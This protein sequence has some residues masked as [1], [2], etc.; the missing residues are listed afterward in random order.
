MAVAILALFYYFDILLIWHLF[1]FVTINSLFESF[2]NPARGSMLQSLIEPEQYIK[3]SSWLS[4][5]SVFGSLI[6]LSIAALLIAS[7]GIWGTILVDSLTFLISG[8]IIYLISFKDKRNPDLKKPKVKDYFTLILQGFTYLKGKKLIIGLLVL[9]AFINFSLVPYNVL[10]PVYVDEVLNLG[11]KGLSYM[12]ISILLGMLIGGL[13]MGIKRSKFNQINAI[14]FGLSSMGL[15]YLLLGVPG[16]TNFSNS[17]NLLYVL[18][19]TFFFGFFVPMVQA[20][21]QTIMMKTTPPEMIGR[22]SS[23]MGVI[24]LCAMPLGGV[25]VLFIG[26]SI[27]VS[28]LFI[29]M[30]LSGVILSISFWIKNHN[31]EVV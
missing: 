17:I 28:L 3:G 25:V 21:T 31:I 1:I 4:T 16:Y 9:A 8:L 23:I 6:G 27:S 7:I 30:G 2:A 24:A 26:D 13:F 29:L 20:P 12:G 5:A 11:I 22:L 15:M 19:I 14:G 18:V 10:K